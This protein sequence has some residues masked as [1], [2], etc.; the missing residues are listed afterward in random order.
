MGAP[1]KI[2][3]NYLCF[4]SRSSR[5]YIAESERR[6]LS[7]GTLRAARRR[8]PDDKSAAQQAGSVINGRVRL[9]K[10]SLSLLFRISLALDSPLGTRSAEN[11]K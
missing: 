11:A 4:L 5:V 10:Y 2:N 1:D 6:F 3:A 8:S 7:T 9:D